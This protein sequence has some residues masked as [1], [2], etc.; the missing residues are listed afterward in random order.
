[1]T[2]RS[3][4]AGWTQRDWAAMSRLVSRPPDDFAA[5]NAAVLVDLGATKAR[6][7]AGLLTEHAGS[8][9]DPVTEDIDLAG[10]GTLVVHTTLHL[11]ERSGRWLVDWSEATIDPE[12][13]AGRHFAVTTTW[14]VRAPILGAGG[15]PLTTEAPIVIIGI[16][17]SY[18]KDATTLSAALIAAGA[19]PQAVRGALIA[20]KAHPTWFEPVFTVTKARYLQLKPTIYPLPGTVFQASSIRAAITPGLEA[21]VVGNVGPITAQELADLGPP[22]TVSSVVGQTGLE[23]AYERQLAG[24]PGATVTVV[25]PNGTTVARI[26]TFRPKPGRPLQTSIDP[27]VQQAAEK[28]LA[29]ETKSSALI[30]VQAS[31]GQV[32]AVVS[33][34][35][36]DGF[37]LAL[38]GEFPPGSTFKTVT[39]TAL[40][41]SGLSPAS[42][43]R[44]PTSISVDGEVFHNA[45]GDAPVQNL[46]QAF[47]ESCNTAFIGLATSRLGLSSLPTAARLYDIGTTPAMGLAAFGGSVPVPLNEADLAATAIGQSRV[48]VSPLVMAMVAADLDNGTVHEPKLVLGAPADRAPTHGLSKTVVDDLHEMMA[49]VVAAGTAAGTGLPPG[50]YAKTGTAEYGTST[51]PRTDAWLMGFNGDVAFAVLVV[52]GGYGGPTDGPIAAKF[53]DELG[54]AKLKAG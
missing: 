29:R 28:A 20:A 16:E 22:Y 39:S 4:L 50:T 33:D 54:N 31:T 24:D 53:L 52:D 35:S 9:D 34:P 36:S 48:V 14:P 13:S 1:M 6:Y 27:R 17:G 19:P 21:H 7:S 44:C 8:A 30:A 51:P 26:A 42:A 5:A 46:A 23:Q 12:L 37:D 15:V 47:A 45:E 2:V 25:A 38:D 11:V 49:D 18:V 32:I 10:I 3:F 40:I 43:A 41:E